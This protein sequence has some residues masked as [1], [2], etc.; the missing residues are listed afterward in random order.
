M[1]TTPLYVK[2]CDLPNK[3]DND[4]ALDLCEVC[5]GE[6]PDQVIEAQLYKGICQYI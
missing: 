2:H 1:I 5:N 6:T 3:Q 4:I